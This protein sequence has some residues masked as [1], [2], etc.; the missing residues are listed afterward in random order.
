MSDVLP[1]QY[2]VNYEDH[3]WNI[4][5]T[6]RYIYYN[7]TYWNKYFKIK[8][9]TENTEIFSRNYTNN[10]LRLFTFLNGL[11]VLIV[12]TI[13]IKTKQSFIT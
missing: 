7:P 3:F 12:F 13:Y 6:K 8:I 2:Q 11:V 1:R 9:L 5:L 10:F 4:E